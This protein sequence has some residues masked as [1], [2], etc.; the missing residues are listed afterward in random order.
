MRPTRQFLALMACGLVT[1]GAQDVLGD[2]TIFDGTNI[3]L[4][5][6]GSL[7]GPLGGGDNGGTE[8]RLSWNPFGSPPGY[9]ASFGNSDFTPTGG[10]IINPVILPAGDNR[11]EVTALQN[12][13]NGFD[14]RPGDVDPNTPGQDPGVY[15]PNQLTLRVFMTEVNPD[16]VFA[17]ND[18]NTSADDAWLIWKEIYI[19]DFDSN[20]FGPPDP[21]DDGSSSFVSLSDGWRTGWDQL[22]LLVDVYSD[23]NLYNG[24]LTVPTPDLA[25]NAFVTVLNFQGNSTPGFG[26][27]PSG[28]TPNFDTLGVFQTGFQTP[29][30]DGQLNGGN[31]GLVDVEIASVR[32]VVPEPNCLVLGCLGAVGLM[33][34]RRRK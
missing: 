33:H 34:K 19:Y 27:Q 17:E 24:P 12:P 23:P 1:L 6:S 21:N 13:L 2:T 3:L 4:S 16:L 25:Q 18:P 11:I 28:W 7:I 22:T 30:F 31:T 26:A 9:D 29:T 5:N 20:A 32:I 14:T 8:V 15:D 10:N